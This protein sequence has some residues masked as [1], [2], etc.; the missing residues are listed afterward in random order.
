MPA[1]VGNIVP[2][3]QHGEK[4]AVAIKS[5]RETTFLRSTSGNVMIQ[6]MNKK[7]TIEK[8]ELRKRIRSKP[9]KF[10]PC[11]HMS[12]AGRGPYIRA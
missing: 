5:G 8:Q 10:R 3:G 11:K 9:K 12:V 6:K 1:L 4:L 2:M 7:S